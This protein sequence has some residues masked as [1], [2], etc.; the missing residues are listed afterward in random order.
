MG[1]SGMAGPQHAPSTGLRTPIAWHIL[2]AV[3]RATTEL[4]LGAA[5]SSDAGLETPR[6]QEWAVRLV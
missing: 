6:G 3:D 1:D 4:A 2:A 5:G